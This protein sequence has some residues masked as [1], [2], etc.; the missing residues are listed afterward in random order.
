MSGLLGTTAPLASDVSMLAQLVALAGLGVGFILVKRRRVRLHGLVVAL[1]FL[2]NLA[3]TL[4]VMVPVAQ[5]LFRLG[6]SGLGLVIKFH[7]LL[8]AVVVGLAGYILV[9]WRLQEPGP[10]C[11]Q[12]KPWM[13]PLALAWT[14]QVILG[15][16]IYLRLY[17]T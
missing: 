2:A 10:T 5:R 4:L 13:L 3:S 7:A 11:W 14:A 15:M 6:V 17:P 16:L 8:G 12:R 9:E 1:S